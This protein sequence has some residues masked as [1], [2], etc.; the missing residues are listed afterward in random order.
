MNLAVTARMKQYAVAHA[1]ASAK[2][3]PDDLVAAPSSHPRDLVGDANPYD[4]RWEAYFEPRLDLKMEAN[5]V[6]SP[7]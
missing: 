1:I 6:Q 2:N 5:P 3:P 7:R 4:P